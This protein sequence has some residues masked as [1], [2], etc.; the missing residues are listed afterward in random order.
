MDSIF[1]LYDDA[2]ELV[3]TIVARSVREAE[4]IAA[5]LGL[6][7]GIPDPPEQEEIEVPEPVDVHALFEQV[8]AQAAVSAFALGIDVELTPEIVE[9]ATNGVELEELQDGE[10]WRAG[11]QAVAGRTT[12]YNGTTWNIE[13][14][15]ITQ[16]SW[17]PGLA[18]TLFVA[19][20]DDFEAWVQPLGAHDAYQAGARVTHNGRRWVSDV[21]D[22]I[23]E[24]GVHGWTELEDEA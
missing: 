5:E 9:R 19:V 7:L 1:W 12:T 20:R 3:N 10:E 21:D 23:W 2:G 8:Q 17:R 14:T 18:P 13:K 6:V 15:H 22:N 24:P 11:V 16:A 4:E